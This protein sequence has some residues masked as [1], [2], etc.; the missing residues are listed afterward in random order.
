MSIDQQPIYAVVKLSQLEP[1]IKEIMNV[2]NSMVRTFFD[3]RVRICVRHTY[4]KAFPFCQAAVLATFIDPSNGCLFRMACSVGDWLAG[5]DHE[6]NKLANA[7]TQKRIDAIYEA[8]TK[9]IG[10][11]IALVDGSEFDTI[12]ASN[13]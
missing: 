4:G 8:I 2:R 10:P 6:H 5:P 13:V 3:S 11:G 12:G 1:F 7:D 9:A